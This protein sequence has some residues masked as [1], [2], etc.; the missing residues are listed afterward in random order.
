[1]HAFNVMEIFQLAGRGL[2]VITDKTYET[3]PARLALKIGDPVEF[4][5]TSH[6]LLKTWVTGI[7][8]LDPWSPK[9]TFAFTLP[10]EVMKDDIPVGSEIWVSSASILPE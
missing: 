1:M 9:H 6:T 10:F 3:L 2:V 8:H 5:Q 4:R 7:E